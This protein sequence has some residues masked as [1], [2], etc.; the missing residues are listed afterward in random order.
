MIPLLMIALIELSAPHIEQAFFYAIATVE[1]QHDD[2]AVG[3]GGRSRGRYQICRAYWS[4]ACEHMGVRYGYDANVTN[5]RVCQII[6]RAYWRRYEV[7]TWEH[8]ARAH[9][10]GG[11]RGHRKPGTIDYWKRV[12]ALF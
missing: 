3:D 5:L 6:M 11:P 8:K 12:K 7:Y 9:N 4:D 1:S 10:G 2:Y